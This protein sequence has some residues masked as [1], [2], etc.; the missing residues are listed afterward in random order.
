MGIKTKKSYLVSHTVCDQDNIVGFLRYCLK[1]NEKIKELCSYKQIVDDINKGI[2]YYTISK[3][4]QNVKGSKIKVILKTEN[5]DKDNKYNIENLPKYS[6]T[7]EE[8][9][10]LMVKNKRFTK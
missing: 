10:G 7:A 1:D 5:D 2:E 3:N 6:H 9:L 8:L 4:N